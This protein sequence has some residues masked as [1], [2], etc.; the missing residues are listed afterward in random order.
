MSFEKQESGDK[1]DNSE[2]QSIQDRC[3]RALITLSF[4]ALPPLEVRPNQIASHTGHPEYKSH[5]KGRTP[6]STYPEPVIGSCPK[7]RI[8]ERP[9]F[10]IVSSSP[11][12]VCQKSQGAT[13]EGPSKE[14]IPRLSIPQSSESI[15]Q[16]PSLIYYDTIEAELIWNPLTEKHSASVGQVEGAVH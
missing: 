16:S 8:N 14:S 5:G 1:Y 9:G 11:Q 6:F 4:V 15:T 2:S 12:L 7:S 10:S 3:L 13:K